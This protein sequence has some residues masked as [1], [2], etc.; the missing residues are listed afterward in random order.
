MGFIFKLELED[1]T[2]ADPPMLD[3]AVPNWRARGKTTAAKESPAR[4]D[5]GGRSVSPRLV[6]ALSRE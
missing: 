5:G 3:T 4:T 1:G 2:P 6:R